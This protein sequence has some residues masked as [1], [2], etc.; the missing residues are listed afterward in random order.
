MHQ[1][2]LIGQDDGLNAIAHAELGED[3]GDVGLDRRLGIAVF[4]AR[5]L[6]RWVGVT[7]FIV[8]L[9]GVAGLSGGASLIPDYLLFAGLFAVGVHTLRS[10]R[11]IEPAV[12]VAPRAAVVQP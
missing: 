2:A 11:G 9:L 3:A 12:M 10:A 8:P 5:V 1:P 7:F 6:P 4:R